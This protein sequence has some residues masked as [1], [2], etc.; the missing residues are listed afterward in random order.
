[1]AAVDP[2][3]YRS[4][5]HLSSGATLYTKVPPEEWTTLFAKAA[6]TK[7][8]SDTTWVP[9]H[10]GRTV[11]VQLRHIAFVEPPPDWRPRR[12]PGMTRKSKATEKSFGPEYSPESG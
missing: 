11:L 2:Q 8:E 4:R 1:M 10:D 7:H 12:E 6:S 3:A 9:L 5:V